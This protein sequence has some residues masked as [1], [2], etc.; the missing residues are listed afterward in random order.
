[1]TDRCP[2]C[3]RTRDPNTPTLEV[4]LKQQVSNGKTPTLIDI[5]K[6]AKDVGLW[7]IETVDYLHKANRQG[8]ISIGPGW[9]V[10]ARGAWLQ[11][12]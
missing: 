7:E 2:H 9:E 6:A 12:K 11:N 3:G 4:F 1:M 5:L 8:F 10:S